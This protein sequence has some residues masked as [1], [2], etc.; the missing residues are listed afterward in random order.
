MRTVLQGDCL[1][2]CFAWC[3]IVLLGWVGVAHGGQEGR[4]NYSFPDCSV[5]QVFDQLGRQ[6]GIQFSVDGNKDVPAKRRI[7]EGA[8]VEEVIQGVLPAGSAIVWEYRYGKLAVV[9]VAMV[10]GAGSRGRGLAGS[11]AGTRTWATEGG[12]P[13]SPPPVMLPPPADN[14]AFRFR[15]EVYERRGTAATHEVLP[16]GANGVGGGQGIIIPPEV[17]PIP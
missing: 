7:F 15:T 3:L 6:T 9:E 2:G 4:A 11:G 17:V 5:G 8:T 16:P 12:R 14:P 10:G 13:L 1:R